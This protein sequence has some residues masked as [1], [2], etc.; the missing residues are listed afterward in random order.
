M[1]IY[2]RA[3]DEHPFASNQPIEGCDAGVQFGMS[4]CVEFALPLFHRTWHVLHDDTHAC[5]GT[6]A[7]CTGMEAHQLGC[8]AVLARNGAR[9]LHEASVLL[10]LALG[11]PV[12]AVGV[13]V[14]AACC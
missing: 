8:G 13:G 10:A 12:R 7:P 11:R 2:M 3:C 6:L 9:A 14:P 1:S 5:R 4:R